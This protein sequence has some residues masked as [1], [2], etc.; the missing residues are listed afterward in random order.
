MTHPE[1]KKPSTKL[2][3]MQEP[4]FAA[5]TYRYRYRYI[6]RDVD[7]GMGRDI[8]IDIAMSIGLRGLGDDALHTTHFGLAR[9]RIFVAF[10]APGKLLVLKRRPA[11]AW[12][13]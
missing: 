1:P 2:K 8:D 6:D 13:K 5:G 9:S 10:G 4:Q 3:A 11:P 12:A 7:V